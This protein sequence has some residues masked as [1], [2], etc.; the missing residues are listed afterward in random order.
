MS[1]IAQ[2][3]VPAAA[4]AVSRDN[5]IKLAQLPILTPRPDPGT[6]VSI[7][8]LSVQVQMGALS[9]VHT[10]TQDIYKGG[11][12][13]PVSSVLA[14]T[15]LIGDCKLPYTLCSR[16]LLLCSEFQANTLSS[17]WISRVVLNKPR[18]HCSRVGGQA[19]TR[20]VFR[21]REQDGTSAV[22]TLATIW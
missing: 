16:L 4:G 1:S 5:G 14:N 17:V 2:C 22:I 3:F 11:T 13:H 10:V 19:W 7:S 8:R 12:P 15:Q 21:T 9:S 18:V 20:A 6:I